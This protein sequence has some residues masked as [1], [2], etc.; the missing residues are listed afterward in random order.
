[1]SHRGVDLFTLCFFAFTKNNK[2][3]KTPIF[4]T[5]KASV[6]LLALLRFKK[7]L[8]DSYFHLIEGQNNKKSVSS[9]YYDTLYHYSM[10]AYLTLLIVCIVVGFSATAI[11]LTNPYESLEDLSCSLQPIF[12]SFGQNATCEHH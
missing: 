9:S 10:L 8:F 4:I 11:H 1:M 6:N 7:M 2:N 5:C 3:H 12:Q